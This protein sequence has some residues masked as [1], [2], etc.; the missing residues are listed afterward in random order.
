[1][2]RVHTISLGCPKNRVDTERMLG[3]L[4]AG[5]VAAHSPARADLVLINTCSF[6]R[7]AVEESVDTIVDVVRQAGEAKARPLVAVAGCLVSRYGTAEL[8]AALPEVDL[9]L[10]T[11]ELDAWPEMIARA[12]GLRALPA[13]AGPDGRCVSTMPSYAYL[14]I[15]EGCGHN[16]TFC[17]IPAIR[18]RPNP[19]PI[20]ALEAEARAL[21][22][23]GIKELVLVAQDVTAYPGEAA[24]VTDRG[25]GGKSRGL[26]T[27]LTR[28]MAV[29]DLARLRLMYLYPAGLTH[30]L[31]RFLAEATA[32]GPL[33]PYFDVPLQHAHPDI[34]K[35]MGRPFAHDPD[36]VVDRI[37]HHL[38]HAALRT[39][40]I[41]GFPGERPHHFKALE[42]FVARA[43]FHHLGVFAYQ[44]EEGT[45][46]A[47]M[48]G[49]VGAAVKEA[50]R[51]R[52]MA[53]Q[54]A[55]SED[56]LSEWEGRSVE[57]LVDAAHPEW[58]GLHV[59]R[60]WFQAPEVDGVTYV[61]GE[62][63][64]PGMLVTATVEEAKAYDL[65]ALV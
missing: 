42:A 29:P 14:K 38:P 32:S 62:G 43:R 60:T 58:P 30:D 37:R 44:R 53:M 4:G 3:A 15:S 17:T 19:R 49:Q 22:G 25:P 47:G 7:P 59:G 8:A 16:C 48:P 50:R 41:V 63:V 61:S 31:L 57:V 46:A 51:D 45:P 5:C 35:R 20:D 54:Q 6:I 56:I 1:M 24:G 64:A 65:V 52:I 27:L 11:W 55:I 26:I 18:G 34:L 23:A 2:I 10:H 40:L 33:V 39:S 36:E 12:L 9:W 21:A 13:P 28:L